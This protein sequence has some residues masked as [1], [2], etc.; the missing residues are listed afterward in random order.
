MSENC[1]NRYRLKNDYIEAEFTNVG[2]ALVSLKV[3]DRAGKKRD[4]VLGYDDLTNYTSNTVY[5]GAILGRMA[6]E[7]RPPRFIWNGRQVDLPTDEN[8][9]HLHGGADGITFKTWNTECADETK[10]RFTVLSTQEASGYPEDV[11]FSAEY[12]LEG[13]A[14][15]LEYSASS[16]EPTPVNMTAHPYFNLNGHESGDVSGHVL[17]IHADEYSV[18]WGEELAKGTV[19]SCADNAVLDFRKAKEIGTH[20]YDL[21]YVLDKKAEYDTELWSAESGIRMR[22][23]CSAPC[24]QCYNACETNEIGKGGAV[25]GKGSAICL[26]P[27]HFPNN[28]NIPEAETPFA[29]AKQSYKHTVRYEFDLK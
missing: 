26:E 28:V 15:C 16:A 6:G 9:M 17:R 14:L 8:G 25:Y 11:V 2:A 19:F 22:M 5:F 13:N 4:I 12:R 24:I 23:K 29:D 1:I 3:N 20:E 10:L 27:Q 18:T 7:V 21:S